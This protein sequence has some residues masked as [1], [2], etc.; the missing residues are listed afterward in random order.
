MLL[1]CPLDQE[2]LGRYT[3][4]NLHLHKML[5]LVEIFAHKNTNLFYK[6]LNLHFIGVV[7]KFYLR[8]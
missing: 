4:C 7:L 6:G 2:R 3:G 1:D 5:V 8:H